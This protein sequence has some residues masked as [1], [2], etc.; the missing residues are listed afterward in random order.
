MSQTER[1]NYIQ[2]ILTV[3]AMQLVDSAKV[4]L[5]A[6]ADGNTSQ[7]VLGIQKVGLEEVIKRGWLLNR[8]MDDLSI[9][10][11]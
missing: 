7:V 8:M 11:E 9:Q 5:R 1:A 3:T 10:P 4:V 2:T 6:M